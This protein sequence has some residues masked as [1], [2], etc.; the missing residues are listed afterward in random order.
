MTR[1]L[2]AVIL[3]PLVLLVVIFAPPVLYLA[4]IGIIG[5][6]CLYE[7]SKLMKT[8]QIHTRA[9]LAY[10]IFWALLVIFYRNIIPAIPALALTVVAAFTASIWRKN[11]TVQQ[12]T[13]GL[14]AELFGIFYI[15]LFLYPL[16]PIRFAY[17]NTAGLQWTLLL[18]L[19]TWGGD[20]VALFVGKTI[21]KRPFAPVL[22]PNKTKEG[23]IFG[24]LASIVIAIA[25]KTFLWNDLPF[26]H[27]IVVSVLLGLFGQLGD[28]GESMIKRAAGIKDSSQL[29]PGHGGV[30]DRMDSLLFSIPVL[31]AYLMFIE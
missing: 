23:A 13:Y 31:Y 15:T 10:C 20:T 24:L 19:V 16:F 12:R 28:L 11:L 30:L 7:Y 8:M 1:I 18:L 26:R 29:I 9:W 5:T 6:V 3:I 14:L 25:L 2:S 21:G 17:G 4:G 22:S 27:V